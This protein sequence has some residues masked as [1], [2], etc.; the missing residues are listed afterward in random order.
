[1]KLIPKLVFDRPSRHNG[2][3]AKRKQRIIH[4]HK[5]IWNFSCVQLDI[6]LKHEK[7]NS[8]SPLAHVLFSLYI[9]SSV[10]QN[11]KL[12]AERNILNIIIFKYY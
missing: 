3:G 9:F 11:I 10:S 4:E 2:F 6:S 7:R 8:T 1:M 5:G 12:V